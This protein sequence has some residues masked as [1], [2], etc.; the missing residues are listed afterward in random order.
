MA[1][2]VI[3][4]HSISTLS[5]S[6]YSKENICFCYSSHLSKWLHRKKKHLDI[7]FFDRFNHVLLHFFLPILNVDSLCAT[8]LLCLQVQLN[9]WWKFL[10]EFCRLA[11][12]KFFF[13]KLSNLS[14]LCLHE[15][16]QFLSII[17]KDYIRPLTTIEIGKGDK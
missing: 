15:F 9:F 6:Y 3:L 10:T 1:P 16:L 17:L 7:F 12:K 14:C 5:V 8:A 4:Y 2:L 13:L 11:Q